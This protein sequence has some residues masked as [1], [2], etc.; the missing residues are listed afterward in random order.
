M[1]NALDRIFNREQWITKYDK[2][3]KPYRVKIDGEDLSEKESQKL[4]DYKDLRNSYKKVISELK[5]EELNLN[6]FYTT[7]KSRKGFFRQATDLM[8]IEIEEKARKSN[9][10]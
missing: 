9:G 8:S 7:H 6:N 3:G 5:Y 4:K 1:Y 10:D 2:Q